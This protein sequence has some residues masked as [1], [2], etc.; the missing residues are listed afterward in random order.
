MVVRAPQWLSRVVPGAESAAMAEPGASGSSC[1]L[2][3]AVQ[4]RCRSCADAVRA[5]LD[6]APGVRLLELRPEAQSVLVET[7]VAAERV[8][9]LLERSG[10]RAV[11][12]GMG[13]SEAA[14]LGAA[15]AALSGP[16]AVRGLVRF[17]QVSPTR[18]LVDG[19]VDGLPPG[20][21]GL[22][23]HEFGDLSQPCDRYGRG[24]GAHGNLP[25]P[26]R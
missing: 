24:W 18:C 14:S 5:A 19:A 17:L 16:G 25:P 20:P 13:G 2:E 11:L 12:K 7:T 8:R 1:R 21:H 15:V 6:G 23:V 9:E 10:R 4:M 22:H 3:F 26:P